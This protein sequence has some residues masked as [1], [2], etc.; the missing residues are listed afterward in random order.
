[1]ERV[2]D[3]PNTIE[4]FENDIAFFMTQFMEENKIDNLRDISQNVWNGM[5]M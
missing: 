5:L 3:T 4:V 1:M 2:Q